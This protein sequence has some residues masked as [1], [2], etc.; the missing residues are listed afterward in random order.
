MAFTVVFLPR[1][2]GEHE[3]LEELKEH[4]L[5]TLYREM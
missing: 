3:L 2:K 5:D 4:N 1:A